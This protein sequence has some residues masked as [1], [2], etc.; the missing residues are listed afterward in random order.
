[1]QVVELDPV[2]VDLAKDHF[3]FTEDEKLK[4]ISICRFLLFYVSVDGLLAFLKI[5]FS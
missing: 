2:V 1:M 5:R 3:G 4:V